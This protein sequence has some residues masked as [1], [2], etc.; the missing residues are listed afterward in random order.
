MAFNNTMPYV[1]MPRR[2]LYFNKIN[3]PKI[4]TLLTKEVT[5]P[6]TGY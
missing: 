1:V 3:S 6:N 2:Q 5:M 4:F